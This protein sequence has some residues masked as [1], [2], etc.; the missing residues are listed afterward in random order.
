MTDE[1]ANVDKII[2]FHIKCNVI[3]VK[4]NNRLKYNILNLNKQNNN[5]NKSM[6]VKIG[7]VNVVMI[8]TIKIINVINVKLINKLIE[9][10]IKK[11]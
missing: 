5:S 7:Y 8:I 1:N 6:S 11:E 4:K 10:I 2:I 3:N 9:E